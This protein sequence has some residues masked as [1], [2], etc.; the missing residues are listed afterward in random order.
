M[1]G[2]TAKKLRLMAYSLGRHKDE[3]E[4][5]DPRFREY[6]YTKKGTRINIGQRRI[7]QA[8]KTEYKCWV[9]NGRK[10]NENAQSIL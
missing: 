3:H 5:N 4:A 2:K 8:L 6:K 10:P 9:R 1:R 7:Y